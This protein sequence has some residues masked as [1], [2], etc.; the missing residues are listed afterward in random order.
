MD[1]MMNKPLRVFLVQFMVLYCFTCF[2]SVELLSN[3]ETRTVKENEFP[4]FASLVS[5]RPIYRIFCCG[6]LVTGIFVLTTANCFSKYPIEDSVVFAG[7]S[8]LNLQGTHEIAEWISYSDW[9]LQNDVSHVPDDTDLGLVR[10]RRPI[11]FSAN[12]GIAQLPL[13]YDVPIQNLRVSLVGWPD[14]YG[15]ENL[16]TGSLSTIL[17][18]TCKNSFRNPT[19]TKIIEGKIFCSQPGPN[20]NKNDEGGPVF[21]NGRVLVGINYWARSRDQQPSMNLHINYL[22]QRNFIESIIHTR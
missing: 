20:P 5:L 4:S 12:I 15:N 3:A 22:L 13:Q 9:A 17:S 2:S 6:T 8:T 21:Y 16:R 14:I 10:L 18:S 7:F 11:S 19:Q 1:S